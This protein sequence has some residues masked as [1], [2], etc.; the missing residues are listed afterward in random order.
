MGKVTSCE[1]GR[2]DVMRAISHKVTSW[3]SGTEHGEPTDPDD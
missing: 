3:A 1:I 2:R